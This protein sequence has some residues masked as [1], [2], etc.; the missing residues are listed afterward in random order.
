V[1][2]TEFVE[3]LEPLALAMRAEM[4]GPTWTAYYRALSDV[5]APLLAAVVDG[6]FHQALEFFPKAP[7]LRAACERQRRAVLAAN[8]HEAC[9]DCE[10]SRGWCQVLVNDVPKVQRCPCVARH[11]QRLE[12]LGV[13]EPLAA[14]P[15]EAAGDEQVYPSFG[16]LP[17]GIRQQLE[18]VA[19]RKQL[20]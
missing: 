12:A 6:M 3:I 7:E 18:A 17:A 19:A 4:D 14:L 11:Q 16:Q 2:R 10:H 1:E 20:R 15:A 9:C 8:P 13:R 5:A